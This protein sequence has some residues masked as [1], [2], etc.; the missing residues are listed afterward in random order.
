MVLQSFKQ[1]VQ[2]KGHV[3]FQPRQ[4]LPAYS[5]LRSF[6]GCDFPRAA[7][8]QQLSLTVHYKA[9][10][11]FRLQFHDNI[12]PLLNQLS[13]LLDEQIRPQLVL[14]VMFPGT[15]NSSLP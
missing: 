10:A 8:S 7:N 13:P 6:R 15:A 12:V 9:P 4:K 5:S 1:Y 11:V 3:G 2:V 14:E